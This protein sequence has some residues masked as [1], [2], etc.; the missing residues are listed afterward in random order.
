MYCFRKSL[1]KKKGCGDGITGAGKGQCS[2]LEQNKCITYRGQVKGDQSEAGIKSECLIGLVNSHP[3][4]EVFPNTFFEEVCFP[5]VTNCFHLFKWV[6]C[7][8]VSSAAKVKY[9]SIGT[10]L[11]VVV[12]HG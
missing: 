11:D 3:G 4:F 7:V 10:E 5:L 9:E 12:H 6:I 1:G 8:V 2:N